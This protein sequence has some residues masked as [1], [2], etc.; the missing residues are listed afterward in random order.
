MATYNKR[1]YKTPKE[2]EEKVLLQE[3]LIHLMKRLTKQKLGLK[4]TKSIF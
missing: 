4:K 2:K 3:Y 1:G